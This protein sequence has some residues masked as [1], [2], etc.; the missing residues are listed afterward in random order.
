M[1]FSAEAGGSDSGGGF[2]RDRSAGQARTRQSSGILAENLA[3]HTALLEVRGTRWRFAHGVPGIGIHLFCIFAF[4]FF[5]GE[6]LLPQS[7]LFLVVAREREL[8]R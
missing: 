5:S 1:F 3:G 7:A 2:R 6:Q 8:P 4:L